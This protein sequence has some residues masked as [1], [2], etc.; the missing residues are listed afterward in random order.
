MI[1]LTTK[2]GHVVEPVVSGALAENGTHYSAKGSPSLTDAGGKWNY[3]L[4]Q[5]LL[6]QIVKLLS[7]RNVYV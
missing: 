5:H 3:Y 4:L 1:I 7:S 6:W 2:N